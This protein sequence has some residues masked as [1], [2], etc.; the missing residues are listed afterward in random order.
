[1]TDRMANTLRL[2]GPVQGISIAHVQAMGPEDAA[3]LSL[4]RAVRRDHDITTRHHLATLYARLD[5]HDSA[6]LVL[7]DHVRAFDSD[8]RAVARCDRLAAVQPDDPQA[9]L[10]GHLH[11]MP[12][13]RDPRW[14]LLLRFDHQTA[15]RRLEL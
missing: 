14:V 15:A 5:R 7:P 2:V 8:H 10:A 1:M 9:A 11:E 4:V 6:I 3:V 12:V 13:G